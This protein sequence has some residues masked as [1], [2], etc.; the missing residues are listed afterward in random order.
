MFFLFLSFGFVKAQDKGKIEGQ[1]ENVPQSTMV[2]LYSVKT[3]LLVKSELTSDNGSFVFENLQW[4]NYFIKVTL[5]GYKV[6]QSKNF[7]VNAENLRIKVPTIVLQAQEHK[8]N[9][10]IVQKNKAFVVN[11]IDR[12]VVNVDALISTA[13]GDALDVLAKS[14]GILVDEDGRITFK[15]KS[16]VSVF[17]D[18]KPT[19]LSGSELESYLKSL[20]AS[21]LDKI[22]LMTNPPAKYDAAGGG[23]VI[24][25]IT[26]KV[27][28]KGLNGSLSSRV[29]QGKRMQSRQGFNLNYINNN[30]RIF[31]NVG[32]AV[33]NQFTDLFIFRKFHNENK[34]TKELTTK[35]LFDQYSLI[36]RKSET[37]NAKI[38]LDYYISSKTTFGIGLTG[39][40]RSSDKNSDVKSILYNPNYIE[41]SRIVANNLELGSFKNGG[42]NL[43]FRHEL[44]TIGQKINIDFDYLNY[45]SNTDQKFNNYTYISNNL[46]DNQDELKGLLPSQIAIYSFKSDYSLPLRNEGSFEAGFKSSFSKTDN[47]ADYRDIIKG[48]EV[49]NLDSSNHFKYDEIINA[50][51]VNFNTNYKRFTF[52]SGLRLENTESR[53]DQLGNL[54]NPRKEFQRNYTNFFPTVY[55]MYKLDANGNNKLVLNYGKRIDRPYFQNLNPFVSPLDKFT[56][57][58]GNPDLNPSFSSNYEFTYS[59]KG[60]FSTTLTYGDSKDD[61]GETIEIRD[62]I[63]YSRPG[64]IAQNKIYSVNINADIPFYSWWTANVYSEFSKMEFKSK[65]YTEDLNSSGS[66]FN[67][68]MNNSFKFQKGWSAELS[69]A[70]QSDLVNAQFVLLERSNV[71]FA[72]QKKI[73]SN[74]GSLKLAVNDIFYTNINNGIIKNLKLTDANWTNKPDSRFVSLAFTYSFGK[75]FKAKEYNANGAESEQNR[76]KS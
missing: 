74:K 36:N 20:P 14:P 10:V 61:I 16:G 22:E 24:N 5:L 60:L 48:N 42:V 26:K 57:Y 3:N 1:V 65:L 7:D 18:D 23:G 17:I 41:E 53:G 13:G 58:A 59:Y 2:T 21:T 4:N 37:S 73:L 39:V 75:T 9:E 25:I 33:Q 6:Y 66:F 68:S 55:I 54:V 52:Q 44:D 12:T 8:L 63:Y 45:D 71:N 62:G 76:V 67:F 11:K 46:L 47:T 30:V 43:N 49:Q 51:Y 56:Y 64:N 31:G 32:Y 15:G 19:Y 70:Y 40:Y 28:I 72:V 35:G 50:V 38:G 69:A 27:R 34:E 29:S